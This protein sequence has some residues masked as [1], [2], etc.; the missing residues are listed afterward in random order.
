MDLGMAARRRFSES[1]LV[2]IWEV[3]RACD[4]ACVHCRA[5]AIPLREPD[6]LTTQE[7]RDL[8]REVKRFG[9]PLMVF[10]GGD[11]LKRSDIFDLIAAAR[12]EGLVPFL[13]PSGTP[14]LTHAALHRAKQCGL[15]GISISLDGS[16]EAIH[17]SFRGV[18]GS[19]RAS[20][21]GAA[22]AVG[23]GLTLQINTTL[24]RHNLQDLP[25]IAELVGALEARRWTL[26][27][28]VPTGRG[29][30]VDAVTPQQCETAFRWLAETSPR[31]P[32]RVKTTEGPHY[33]RILLQSGMGQEEETSRGGRFVSGMNDGSGFVFI[34]SRGEIHP[35]GFLPISAGN[36]RHDSLARVYREH[37]LFVALRDPERLHGRC[38]RCEYRSICSGS[39]SRA[40]AAT[41]DYLGEDPACAYR[42]AG[43]AA[44]TSQNP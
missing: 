23:L 18:E 7:G 33:R 28:L 11:P 22:S 10:T 35:S 27:L 20:L 2:V 24:T 31:L 4:L 26:F 13:S 38:G 19:F 40:Y 16:Q 37:P 25:A 39:R 34:S 21:D 17:D 12:E 5:S 29:E 1:P 32:F 44:V 9:K 42:P 36:V 8:L 6:E 3:T 43:E 14:L 15:T 41:G 30:A